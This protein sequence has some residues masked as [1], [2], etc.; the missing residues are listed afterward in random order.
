MHHEQRARELL[1]HEALGVIKVQTVEELG[2][3]SITFTDNGQGMDPD[4]RQASTTAFYTTKDGHEGIGLSTAEYIVRKHGGRLTV[5]SV[6]GK[7]T[8]VRVMLPGVGEELPPE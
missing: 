5:S 7:G 2:S 3:I 6:P 4:T 1:A 8:V